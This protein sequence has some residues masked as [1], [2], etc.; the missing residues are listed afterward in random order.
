MIIVIA[1]MAVLVVVAAPQYLKY[2]ERGRNSSDRDNMKAIESAVMVWGADIDSNYL[3]DK[4]A[5]V[6]VTGGN[7]G[8]LEV[9]GENKD[10]VKAALENAKIATFA[11]GVDTST[12]ITCQSK[13]TFTSY[14]LDVKVDVKG[15]VTVTT[16]EIP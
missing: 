15:A 16:T 5:T 2:V 8:K 9:A 12:A 7:T 11:S 3:A 14:K 6:T 4:D 1:I 10:A 13:Q